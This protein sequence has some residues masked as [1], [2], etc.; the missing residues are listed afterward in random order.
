MRHDA[1]DV[2]LGNDMIQK[3]TACMERV[4]LYTNLSVAAKYNRWLH[5]FVL[6]YSLSQT[7]ETRLAVTV[8]P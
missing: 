4:M 5:L 8:P 7:R 1:V 2:N 6:L 3:H